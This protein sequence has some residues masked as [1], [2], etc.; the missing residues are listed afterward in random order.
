MYLLEKHIMGIGTS[1]IES[2]RTCIYIRK[3]VSTRRRIRRRRSR[4]GKG[5]SAK[6]NTCDEILKRESK[7]SLFIIRRPTC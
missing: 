2:R 5:K 7:L 4:R 3:H 6:Q 1:A